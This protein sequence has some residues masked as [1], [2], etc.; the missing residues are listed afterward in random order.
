MRRAR[1]AQHHE[2]RQ[3]HGFFAEYYDVLHGTYDADIPFYLDL[4]RKHGG[5]ILELGSGSGRL[6]VP[7]AEAGHEVTGLDASED[8][9]KRCANRLL[10]QP[11][12]VRDRVRLEHGDMLAFS[13]P[14]RFSLVLAACN[15]ILHCVST[16][17]LLAL[18]ERARAHMAPDGLFVV[19]FNIPNVKKMLESDGVEEVFRVTHPE[20]G[21]E[22]VC[23]YRAE[24][25]FIRQLE[26]IYMHLQEFD[27]DRLL[28]AATNTTQRAF[29]FP[30]EVA[31]ALRSSGFRTVRTWTGYRHGRLVESTR[32]IVYICQ[33]SD[34][35]RS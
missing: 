27:R 32:D 15:T 10:T 1:D 23:T 20:A 30:R 21:T 9:L 13:L 18:F 28:R 19:D 34:E 8:M 16:D 4:A 17:Q 35:P 29:Y 22:L 26:T 2:D 12:W 7:L 14:R 25:D 24:Y 11:Q 6:L 3:Y 31:L 33:R 5:P